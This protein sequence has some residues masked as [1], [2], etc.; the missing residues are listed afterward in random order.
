MIKPI[1]P[2]LV[3]SACLAL[4][5]QSNGK[6][7]RD[8]K[9]IS[10]KYLCS[11]KLFWDTRIYAEICVPSRSDG[12]LEGAEQWKPT[13]TRRQIDEMCKRKLKFDWEFISVTPT[14]IKCKG[15]NNNEMH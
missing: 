4:L 3:A 5:D 11:R 8:E 1:V 6:R 7:E 13:I 9:A 15:K 14:D 10:L 2:L 12:W